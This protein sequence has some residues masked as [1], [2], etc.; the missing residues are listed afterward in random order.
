MPLITNNWRDRQIN[1]LK[2]L[3]NQMVLL[4]QE[5]YLVEFL[6][7][8]PSVIWN[9]QGDHSKFQQMCCQRYNFN[10]NRYNGIVAF[11]SVFY[12][13]SSQELVEKI[14]QLINNVDFAY[15]GINRYFIKEHDIDIKLP[16][17]LGDS[18]DTIMHHCCPQ[19]QRVH[20][21]PVVTGAQMVAA[22]PMD[23]YTLCK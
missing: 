2:G 9:W 21:F 4:A 22:H 23:C 12:N 13:L 18:I 20:R 17:D 3:Q 10:N 16:D 8:H 1:G 19:F 11:G 15:I 5:Q 6:N 14:H 7:Q